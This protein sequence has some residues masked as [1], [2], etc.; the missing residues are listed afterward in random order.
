MIEIA[1][2]IFKAPYYKFGHKDKSGQS[3]GGYLKYIATRDGVELL[4]SG[5]VDYIGERKGSNGLFSQRQKGVRISGSE[6][7]RYGGYNRQNDCQGSGYIR[8]V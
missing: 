5:M 1:G 3:R 4:R 2:L 7:E 8:C 6:N